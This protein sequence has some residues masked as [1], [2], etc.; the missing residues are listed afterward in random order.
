MRVYESRLG[1]ATGFCIAVDWGTSALRVWLLRADGAVLGESRSG[2]GADGLAGAAFEDCLNRHIAQFGAA[3]HGLPVVMC[4]MVG[5]RNG[6]REAPYLSIPVKLAA[7]P[8]QA[9]RVPETGLDV[10]IV[11]GLVRR[12]AEAPDVM[13]GEETQLLGFVT[14]V[15]QFAGLVCLPGTHCKWVRVQAGAVEDFY[16]A[17]TGEVYQLLARHSVLRHAVS[18]DAPIDPASVE[19]TQAAKA[20]LARPEALLH[21]LFSVRAA[22]LVAGLP[23]QGA[24]AKLSGLLIGA[25][26]G[27][28]LREVAPGTPVQLVASG[29]LAAL[30]SRVL[31][32][33]GV[34]AGLLDAEAMGQSGLFQAARLLHQSS[35]RSA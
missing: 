32:L 26:V 20:G 31:A 3:A 14:A 34:D 7:L 8:H 17:M 28:A 24:A 21:A 4:G 1:V 11:P 18:A 9:M 22:F 30:Y 27:A 13:R 25:D 19:F 5:A 10:R 2:E 35:E 23:A 16:S 15:P 29:P 12:D 33:A 6:W